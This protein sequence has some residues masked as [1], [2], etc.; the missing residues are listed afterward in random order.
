MK[1]KMKSANMSQ[2]FRAQSMKSL[3]NILLKSTN[4]Q[5]SVMCFMKNGRMPLLNLHN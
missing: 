5:K 1:P 3:W 4:F 2:N